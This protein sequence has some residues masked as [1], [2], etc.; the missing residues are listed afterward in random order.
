LPGATDVRVLSGRNVIAAILKRLTH[1]SANV[2]L[3]T[4]S[5][6]ESLSKNCGLTLHRELASRAFTAGLEKLITDRVG[7]TP[8]FQIYIGLDGIST[9]LSRLP[10]KKSAIGLSV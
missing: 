2:Q 9:L 8:S 1:R 4:L 7:A 6:A 10:T 5:L 3:Y